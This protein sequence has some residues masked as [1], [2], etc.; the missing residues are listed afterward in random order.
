MTLLLVG[1]GSLCARLPRVRRFVADRLFLNLGTR[2]TIPSVPGL[3]DAQPFAHVEA[4]QL[5]PSAHDSLG[6]AYRD[7]VRR[8]FTRFIR[9]QDAPPAWDYLWQKG[10]VIERGAWPSRRQKSVVDG[11]SIRAADA[12]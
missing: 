3:A 6:T 11:P 8:R 2:A 7:A 1:S 12:A 4:L 9:N 5:D 10:R